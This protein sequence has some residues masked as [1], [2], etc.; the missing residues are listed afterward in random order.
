MKFGLYIIRILTNGCKRFSSFWKFW[1]LILLPDLLPRAPRI[2]FVELKYSQFKINHHSNTP[3]TKG[4]QRRNLQCCVYQ[5]RQGHE[6][7]LVGAFSSNIYFKLSSSKSE[8]Q[9]KL[10]LPDEGITLDAMDM[11]QGMAEDKVVG[12]GRGTRQSP[13]HQRLGYVRRLDTFSSN[14]Q[15]HIKRDAMVVMIAA[16]QGAMPWIGLPK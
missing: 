2:Y 1:G 4:D 6:A 14:I 13:R 12:V 9:N 7:E 10:D 8:E 16:G 5:G 11:V 3:S 15:G